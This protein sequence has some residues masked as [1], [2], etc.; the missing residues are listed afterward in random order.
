MKKL[1]ITLSILTIAFAGTVFAQDGMSDNNIGIYL[2]DGSH[3]V[4]AVQGEVLDLH[5][6][7]TNMTSP[8]VAGFEVKMISEGPLFIVESSIAFPTD[9]INV[10]SR[11]GEIIVGFGT[12]LLPEAGSI[13]VMSFSALVSD[14]AQPSSLF[15][16]PVFSPSIPGVPSYL[17]DAQADILVEMRQS[18]GGPSDPVFVVNTDPV[19]VATESTSFDSLKSLY[20]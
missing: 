15:I 17:A 16:M 8:A 9:S 2:A 20:R 19:P 5:L 10:G 3:A 11:Y 7:I 13:E 14:A 6:V 18:T 1:I 4:D 12:P